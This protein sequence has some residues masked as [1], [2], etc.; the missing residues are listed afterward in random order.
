MSI[1]LKIDAYF[2]FF[3]GFTARDLKNIADKLDVISKGK[4][5]AMYLARGFR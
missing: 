4:E 1:E 2:S 5:S 3:W